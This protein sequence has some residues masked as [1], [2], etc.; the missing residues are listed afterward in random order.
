MNSDR[1]L[2][3]SFS[4]SGPLL[5]SSATVGSVS[6]RIEPAL[7]LMRMEALQLDPGQV[8]AATPEVFRVLARVCDHCQCEVRCERDLLCEMA[9]EAVVWEDYCP[10]AF[11]LREMAP[12]SA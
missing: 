7:L 6:A 10:N 12:R 11:R 4:V 2:S 8:K 1:N 5:V 9:G 3:S